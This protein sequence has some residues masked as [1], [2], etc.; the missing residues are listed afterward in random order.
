L[1]HAAIN[2]CFHVSRR[3]RNPVMKTQLRRHAAIDDASIG[4]DLC[5]SQ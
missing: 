3:L 5:I 2:A 1:T 4:R